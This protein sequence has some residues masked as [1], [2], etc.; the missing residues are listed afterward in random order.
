MIKLTNGQYQQCF[1]NNFAR[2]KM[3]LK[4]KIFTKGQSV[5]VAQ[6]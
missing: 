1:R 3:E 5:A 4:I 2:F 6:F